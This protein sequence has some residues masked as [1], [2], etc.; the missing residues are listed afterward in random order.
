MGSPASLIVPLDG[1][2]RPAHKP[3]KVVFPEPYGPTIDKISPF[4]T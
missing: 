4:V 2:S 3:N 1:L